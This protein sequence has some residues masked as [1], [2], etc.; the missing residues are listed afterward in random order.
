[1]SGES[2]H[3]THGA[4]SAVDACRYLAA[5][6][7][8]AVHGAS[9]EELLSERYCPVPAY[10]AHYPLVDEIDEVAAGS[11]KRHDPPEIQGTGYAV[12]S[13]E[14]ALWAFDRSDSFRQG[15]LLSVNLGGDA[16][17]TGAVYGQLAGAFYGEEGIPDTWRA[18]LYNREV[19]ESMAERLFDQ[20][21]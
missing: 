7:V 3:T 9:K 14:S 5:L 16:D 8:G 4:T 11:F 10:W 1:M 18:T 17:T 6:L 12:K 21:E 19:I 13:L 15:C 20:R 2:S